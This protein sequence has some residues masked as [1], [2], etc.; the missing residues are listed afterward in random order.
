MVKPYHQ[1]V[2]SFTFETFLIKQ[3]HL[4]LDQMAAR[5]KQAEHERLIF[6]LEVQ[7]R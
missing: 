4:K 3:M 2:G 5:S 1:C 7:S 6:V